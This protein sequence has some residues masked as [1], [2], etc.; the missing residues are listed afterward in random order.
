MKTISGWRKFFCFFSELDE[1]NVNQS[2]DPLFSRLIWRIKYIHYL[3]KM[4]REKVNKYLQCEVSKLYSRL[5]TLRRRP[6][7]RYRKYLVHV[8]SNQKSLCS[9]HIYTS[10]AVS[11]LMIFMYIWGEAVF[12]KGLVKFMEMGEFGRFDS[13]IWFKHFNSCQ[14]KKNNLNMFSVTFWKERR[15]LTPSTVFVSKGRRRYKP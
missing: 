10:R 7:F 12:L 1:Q 4:V 2:L 14:L 6:Y 9:S 11:F 8:S 3:I 15:T 13:M 5:W